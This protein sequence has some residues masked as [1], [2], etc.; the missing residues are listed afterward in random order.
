MAKGRKPR[1]SAPQPT[2]LGL[3][4]LVPPI[5]RPSVV[6]PAPLAERPPVELVTTKPTRD[7]DVQTHPGY[8]LTARAMV[9][10]F[11]QAEM[12]WTWTQCDLFDDV[13]E[14]DGHL[15][16]QL[17]SRLDAVGGK[18]WIVLPGGDK[19]IDVTAAKELEGALR[20][21]PNF[22][23]T[24]AHQL[25][26]NWYGYSASEIRWNLTQ[27]IIA[28][29]W[30]SE[31]DHRRIMFD[32]KDRSPRYRTATMLGGWTLD[33]GAWWYWRRSKNPMRAGL[34]RTAAWW[35]FFK[36]MSVRDWVVFAERYG[37]PYVLGQYGQGT[38][39]DEKELLKRAVAKLGTDGG[40]V[41]SEL[42]KITIHTVEHGGKTQDVHGALVGLCNSEISKL[43][44]GATLTSET[45]GPG[46]FALGQVHADQAFELRSSDAE[47]LSSSFENAIGKPF[48]QWNGMAGAAA[49][50]LK[51]YV[52]RDLT[53]LV[54]AQILSILGSNLMVPLSLEQIRQEFQLKTP[55]SSADTITGPK[56]VPIGTTP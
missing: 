27:G 39:Q 29:T 11:R 37:L 32:W 52:V 7:W 24:M 45:S 46:S 38:A 20:E 44:S 47:K 19:A 56:V 30:F 14:S 10:A 1:G 33:P 50:K 2:A 40:A 4:P 55:S 48:V 54:R 15:R 22:G 36:R 53:P 51:V 28:P 31:A 35:S 18:P 43:I 41:F 5:D 49:P 25:K 26:M 42:C 34:M 8:G 17:E 9:A 23:D 13:I 6:P 16:S 12:G 3:V 21:V